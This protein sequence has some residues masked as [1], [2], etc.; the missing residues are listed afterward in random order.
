MEIINV[1]IIIGEAMNDCAFKSKKIVFEGLRVPLEQTPVPSRKTCAGE[2]VF[3]C[4]PITTD[5]S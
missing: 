5:R 3:N 1:T 2:I 4:Y